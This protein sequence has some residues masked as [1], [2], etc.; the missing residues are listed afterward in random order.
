M[1]TKGLLKRLSDRDIK[2]IK[3]AAVIIVV[4]FAVTVLP[5]WWSHWAKVR[6]DIRQMQ[7]LIE[8]A[9]SGRFNPAGLATMVPVFEMPKDLETQK[10]RFR[11][12]LTRQLRQAGMPNTPLQA[13]PTSRQKVG[14]F[15][16]LSLKY[17]GT[18]R[19]DQLVDFLASL[20]QN[21]YYVAIDELIIR[22]DTKTPAEQRQT[23][24]VEMT[25]CTFVK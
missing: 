4:A 14:G 17:K 24:D 6:A 10:S 25:V 5:K 7:Q 18:C 21:P 19:F 22:A 12:E 23:V 2:A 16:K 3:I 8:D 1:Q 11:D 9:C 13:E 15:T 20:K